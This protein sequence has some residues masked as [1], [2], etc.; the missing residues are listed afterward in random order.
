MELEEKVALL[1]EHSTLVRSTD[2]KAH[3]FRLNFNKF[4]DPEIKSLGFRSANG[5]VFVG[6]YTNVTEV[7]YSKYKDEDYEITDREVVKLLLAY[8]E[9]ENIPL[10]KW[11]CKETG[12]VPGTMK[13]SFGKFLIITADDLADTGVIA[14]GY[15]SQGFKPYGSLEEAQE[16]L[17]KLLSA[18]FGTDRDTYLSYDG[19]DESQWYNYQKIL[20]K[21]ADGTH[22][23]VWSNSERYGYQIIRIA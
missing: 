10:N 18:E 8:A 21:E 16:K 13:T 19:E 23:T 12:Y 15:D 4:S 22:I 11:L 14:D 5:C 9:S 3:N 2:K 17:G 6:E 1:K 7:V 20:N